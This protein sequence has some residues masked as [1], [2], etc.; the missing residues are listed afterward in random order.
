MR[1]SIS[2]LFICLVSTVCGQTKIAN[3]DTVINFGN[4][5]TY[6]RLH[7]YE[8]RVVREENRVLY[9]KISFEGKTEPNLEYFR[10]NDTLFSFI[11]YYES[12][13]KKSTG[14]FVLSNSI[15]HIVDTIISEAP[16]N[17][18]DFLQN[19]VYY[20]EIEK[21]G[22]WRESSDYCCVSQY[23]DYWEGEY[24]KGKRIGIWKHLTSSFSSIEIERINY[25]IDKSS[26]IY[27]NNISPSLPVDS[28]VKVVLGRWVVSSCESKEQT[29]MLYYKCKTY[30]G[31]YGDNC[32]SEANYYDF[33][34]ETTFKRLRG[35]GCNKFKE[36]SKTAKWKIIRE[37]KDTFIIMDFS[38]SKETWKFKLIYL[39]RSGNLVTERQ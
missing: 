17:P 32:S 37:N 23:G 36:S 20:R 24:K 26:P 38:D 34:N 6:E 1:Y 10:I 2:I 22:K 25:D 33:L 30:N 15:S 35:D 9:T 4:Y 31:E 12:G 29:R 14:T 19:L 27:I 21:T 13:N 3:R 39:D 7:G 16:A 5:S 28:L 8:N 11:E 18:A